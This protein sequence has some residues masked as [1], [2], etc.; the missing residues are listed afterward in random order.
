MEG[1]DF[2][3]HRNNINDLIYKDDIKVCAK[4]QKD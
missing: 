1:T 2:Q 4:L 3:N